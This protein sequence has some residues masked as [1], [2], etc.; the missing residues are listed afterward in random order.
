M[1]VDA[2]LAALERALASGDR[3]AAERVFEDA[4]PEFARRQQNYAPK[5]TMPLAS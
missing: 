3:A 2:W 5:P 4:I 1:R